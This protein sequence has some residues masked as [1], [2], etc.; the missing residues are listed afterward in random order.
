MRVCGTINYNLQQTP[1]TRSRNK[2]KLKKTIKRRRR[3]QRQRWDENI[4]DV[5]CGG[6]FEL[7]KCIFCWFLISC[8]CHS[9]PCSAQCT[10]TSHGD[11]EWWMWITM[12]VVVWINTHAFWD[13]V[14]ENKHFVCFAE[15]LSFVAHVKLRRR[16]MEYGRYSLQRYTLVPC[17]FEI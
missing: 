8:Y 1:H 15:H 14:Y 10:C 6:H 11:I 3:P 17:T 9:G 13:L 5:I 2:K 7:S 4:W 16:A 12:N